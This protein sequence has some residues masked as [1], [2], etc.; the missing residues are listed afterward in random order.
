MCVLTVALIDVREQ[1]Y[2]I[3][4]LPIFTWVELGMPGCVWHLLLP[5]EL[6]CWP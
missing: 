6:P 1:M 3:G 2:G 4:S 5:I